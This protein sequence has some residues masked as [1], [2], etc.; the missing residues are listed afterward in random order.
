MGKTTLYTFL[1]KDKES[2]GDLYRHTRH[3]LKY[4]HK[5]LASPLKGKWG[6][7]KSIDERPDCIDRKERFGDFEMDLIIGS[8]QQEAILTLTERKTG[9]AIIEK[10]PNGKNV[11]SLARAVN[12]SLSYFKR[13]GLLHSITTDNGSDLWLLDPLRGRSVFLSFLPNPIVPQT[14]PMLNCS[15]NSFDNTYPKE[16]RSKTSMT[17]KYEI[18]G[19]S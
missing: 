14:S 18:S 11:K 6:R 5:P 13:M 19:D 2:S 16:L 17:N 12:R 7:R 9:Y 4:R 10:L 1:H 3:H 15:T 8:Q